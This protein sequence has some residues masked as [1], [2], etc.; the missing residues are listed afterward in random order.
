[1]KSTD[2]LNNNYEIAKTIYAIVGVILKLLPFIF[3]IWC[4]VRNVHNFNNINETMGA[5]K[6]RRRR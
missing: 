5:W 2:I 6:N 3:L 1:M 4:C